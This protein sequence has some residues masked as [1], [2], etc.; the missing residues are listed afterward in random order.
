M[1]QDLEQR[2]MFRQ[3]RIISLQNPGTVVFVFIDSDPVKKTPI[4]GSPIQITTDRTKCDWMLRE[5]RDG[6]VVNSID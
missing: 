3:A 4:I 6:K 2:K 1:A 5:Y